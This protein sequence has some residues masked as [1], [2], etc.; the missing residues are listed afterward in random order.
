[1]ILN[2]IGSLVNVTSENL[3]CK[4]NWQP[5]LSPFQNNSTPG[6]PCSTGVYCQGGFTTMNGCSVFPRQLCQ[7]LICV[8]LLAKL[9]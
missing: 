9:F 8:F 4:V 1:M 3:G 6:F 2:Y 7:F 5:G